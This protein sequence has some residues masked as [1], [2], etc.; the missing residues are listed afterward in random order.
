MGPGRTPTVHPVP[1]TP[2]RPWVALHHV[3]NSDPHA[4]Q[5][6]RPIRPEPKRQTLREGEIPHNHQMTIFND[7][8]FDRYDNKEQCLKNAEFV[9]TFAKKFGI[10]QWSFIGPGSEKKWYLSENSPQKRMGP[11]CGRY[12]AEICRKWTSLFPCY[13]PIVQMKIEK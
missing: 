2:R 4:H 11:Y 13:D 10:S 8:S 12:A 3:H 5:K 9:K 7:I 6:R 1:G